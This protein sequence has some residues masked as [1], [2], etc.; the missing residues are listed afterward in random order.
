MLNSQSKLLLQKISEHYKHSKCTSY[1]II[2]SSNSNSLT[3]TLSLLKHAVLYEISD[4]YNSSELSVQNLISE[5]ESLTV[6]FYNPQQLS[7]SSPLTINQFLSQFVCLYLSHSINDKSESSPDN[8][9]DLN[10]RID[11][12]CNTESLSKDQEAS[13]LRDNTKCECNSETGDER[14][15]KTTSIQDL[16]GESQTQP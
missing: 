4:R 6:S 5:Q 15:S 16:E 2:V 3:M 8:L 1:S 7:R 12:K 9:I 11:E 13:H 14:N 10:D